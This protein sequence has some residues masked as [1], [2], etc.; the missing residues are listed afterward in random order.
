[1]NHHCRACGRFQANGGLFM[2]M[3]ISRRARGARPAAVLAGVTAVAAAGLALSPAVGASP[4]RPGAR[5]VHATSSG[6]SVTFTYSGAEQTFAVPAGVTSVSVT[7]I[8]AAG[9]GGS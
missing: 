2:N 8:G 7:A 6:V 9:G 5:H 3:H 4:A 1:M